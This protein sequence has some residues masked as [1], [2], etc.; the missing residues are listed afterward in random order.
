MKKNRLYF[1]VAISVVFV[2]AFGIFLGCQPSEQRDCVVMIGDSIFALTGAEPRALMNLAGQSYRTY[3][4]SGAELSGGN[5]ISPRDILGQYDAA[6]RAGSI[7]TLIMDGGGNDYLIGGGLNVEEELRQAWTKL[8]DNAE[9]DGV[10]NI[11]VQGYY[12]TCTATAQQ[13]EGQKELLPLLVS[14]AASR[15]INLIVYNPDDDPWFT[16]KQPIA[17][18][19]ADCIHPSAAASQHMAEMIWNL[20]VQ[21][22]I[23][24]GEGCPSSGSCN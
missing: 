12:R 24:Q 21:N 22:N 16:S 7:R 20:M 6:Q 3:Y 23:E 8:L 9:A 5:I 4:Q 18:T 17:Y 15:G 13:L 14:G 10:E 1:C 19:I 11:I 2:V